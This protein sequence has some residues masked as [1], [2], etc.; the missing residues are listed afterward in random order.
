[1]GIIIPEVSVSRHGYGQP[2]WISYSLDNFQEAI[3]MKMGGLLMGASTSL[4]YV[5]AA[6][7]PFIAINLLGMN[8]ETYGVANCTP[9]IGLI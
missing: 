6:L 9:S 7:A 4:I 1:M 5:F 2:C 3:L 8:S